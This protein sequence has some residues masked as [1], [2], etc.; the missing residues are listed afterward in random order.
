MLGESAKAV[1]AK[2]SLQKKKATQIA[3]MTKD[4]LLIASTKK[5]EILERVH[6]QLDHVDASA[7][8][9]AREI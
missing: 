6:S 4:T 9:R 2:V 8:K 1:L 3:E 7:K 5:K